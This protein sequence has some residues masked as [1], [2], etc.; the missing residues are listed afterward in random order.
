MK[1]ALGWLGSTVACF[2]LLALTSGCEVSDCSDEE[3]D[4]NGTCIQAESQTRFVNPDSITDS[5]PWTSGTPVTIDGEYGHIVVRA[6]AAGDAV[7]LDL[8]GFSYRG[9]SK[10]TEARAEIADNLKF[11]IGS[12][13]TGVLVKTFTE[14]THGS[15]LGANIIVHIPPS[16]DSELVIRNRADGSIGNFEEF[17][18]DVDSAGA[19]TLVDQRTDSD[20]GE[21]DLLGGPSV[22]STR[23][24]CG[25]FVRVLDVSDNVTISTRS[26]TV[27]D[28][29]VQLNV[30][31]VSASATGGTVET[32][33]GT[34]AAT[35]PVGGNF[36]IQALAAT[37]GN[38]SIDAA[39]GCTVEEAAPGSKTVTCGTGGPNYVLTAG[40]DSLGDSNVNIRFE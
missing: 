25:N 12:D 17:D 30:A 2:G 15:N 39:A 38:V 10:E 6:D 21:C 22:V 28:D 33:D 37:Q 4:S 27:L 29:G 19:A 3:T 31:S 8:E 9:A 36:S 7:S 24:N 32:E 40:K 35:F 5:T 34:I 11:S 23:M 13:G 16:F 1:T 20:I 14:G 26:G 18:I